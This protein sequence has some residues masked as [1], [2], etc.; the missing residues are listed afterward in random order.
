MF[1]GLVPINQKFSPLLTRFPVCYAEPRF[2]NR[3]HLGI[4]MP[5]IL[6]SC[7]SAHR[8]L[9]KHFLSTGRLA[10]IQPGQIADLSCHVMLNRDS[11]RH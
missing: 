9:L 2:I 5:I 4:P 11:S 8:M 1:V 7:V 6:V 3:Y 10:G